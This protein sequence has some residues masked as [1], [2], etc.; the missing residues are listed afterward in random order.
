MVIEIDKKLLKD[1]RLSLS[2]AQEYK[3][4]FIKHNPQLNVAMPSASAMIF[5]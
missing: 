4:K 5:Y 2:D 3:D 1:Q